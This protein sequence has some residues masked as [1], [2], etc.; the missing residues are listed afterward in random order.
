MSVTVLWKAGRGETPW[1]PARAS[2]W[3]PPASQEVVTH[4]AASPPPVPAGPSLLLCVHSRERSWGDRVVALWPAT[5]P[6]ASA[7]G[8]SPPP[9]D[10]DS[11]TIPT[12]GRASGKTAPPACSGDEGLIWGSKWIQQESIRAEQASPPQSGHLHL[13]LL[14][15]TPVQGKHMTGTEHEWIFSFE[16]LVRPQCAYS[17]R[18]T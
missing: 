18:H 8:A 1:S 10:T 11:Q 3:L 9:R 17:N 14:Q 6:S 15:H 4:L 13:G 5:L 12:A 16:V 2:V 7:G